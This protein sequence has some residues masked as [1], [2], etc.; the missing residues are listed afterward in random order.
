MGHT[1]WRMNKAADQLKSIL[2][3]APVPQFLNFNQTFALETEASG[4]RIA[5]IVMQHY[6]GKPP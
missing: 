5:A 3:S 4:I 6:E 2:Y 1:S